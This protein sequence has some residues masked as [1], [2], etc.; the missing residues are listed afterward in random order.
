MSDIARYETD[1][2]GVERTSTEMENFL[3]MKRWSLERMTRPVLKQIKLGSGARILDVGCGP[4]AFLD[5]AAGHG[6]EAYG[7]EI[8]TSSWQLANL[9]HS[10]HVHLGDLNSAVF[11]DDFFDLVTMFDV[12]EH[13]EDPLS[14]LQEVRRI[15]KVGGTTCIVT[16]NISSINARLLGT[17]WYQYKP[18]EHLFYFSRQSLHA[19]LMLCGFFHIQLQSVGMYTD[20]GRISCV[21]SA[22]NPHLHRIFRTL[23][24]VL[25]LGH[26]KLWV[27]TG[28]LR[29]IAWKC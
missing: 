29:A 24:G 17:H 7:V 19:L 20:F 3:E 2:F 12:I 18:D 15:L 11:R 23:G 1:Y 16:P 4:G 8:G 6:L 14:T 5:V 21:L 9:R 27:P 25:R 13:L 26:V 22:T 28:H 10:N